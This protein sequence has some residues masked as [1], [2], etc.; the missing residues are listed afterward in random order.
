M[1]SK[2]YKTVGEWWEDSKKQGYSR[3]TQ[4]GWVLSLEIEIYGRSFP[5]AYEKL[6]KD[7]KLILSEKVYIVDLSYINELLEIKNKNRVEK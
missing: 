1:K 3:P 4:A 7:R 5:E 6:I 2:K